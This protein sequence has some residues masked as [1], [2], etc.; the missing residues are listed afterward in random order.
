MIQAA[1]DLIVWWLATAADQL[2]LAFQL[3]SGAVRRPHVT[4]GWNA[5]LWIGALAAVFVL[6]HMLLSRPVLLALV[7]VVA[8]HAS[9]ALV[10]SRTYIAQV[11]R[12]F[13]GLATL[14]R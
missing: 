2:T 6:L 14:G 1:A 3:I 8:I 9:A 7:I 5:A 4:S 13:A 12:L 10:V 11:E